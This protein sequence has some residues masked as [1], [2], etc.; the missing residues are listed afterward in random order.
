MQLKLNP[1]D[2]NLPGEALLSIRKW[3]GAN[4]DLKLTIQR[5]QDDAYLQADSSWN[6]TPYWFMLAALEADGDAHVVAVGPQVVD[7]LL[8][9]INAAFMIVLQD[10]SDHQE[11]AALQ[12]DRQLLASKASGE[13]FSTY[14]FGR[15][16]SP[17]TPEAPPE[18][19][20]QSAPVTVEPHHPPV[21]PATSNTSEPKRSILPFIVL[22]IVVLALLAGAAW[23]WMQRTPVDTVAQ[24]AA[25]ASEPVSE[26]A[27]APAAT[28]SAITLPCDL[29][30]YQAQDELAFVKAC[31]ASGPDSET[32]LKTITAAKDAGLCAVAQRL[33]ANRGQAGDARVALAYAHEYDPKLH[34]PNTCFRDA[35]TSIAAYWYQAVLDTNPDNTEAAERLKELQP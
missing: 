21:T 9:S 34:Q 12:C 13:T 11:R 33:Y 4:T 28:T 20:P 7:P 3:G 1:T 17:I 8:T 26:P 29:S 16:Q 27:P 18:P 30:G 22:G 23:W 35:D 14:A 2:R 6:A 15:L 24:A 10:A 5:N 31:V 19:K 32:L 25:P